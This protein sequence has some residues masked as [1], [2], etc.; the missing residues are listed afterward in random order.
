M[1]NHGELVGQFS[2]GRTAVANNEQIT[3]GIASAVYGAV[4]SA[5][6]ETG[7]NSGDDRPVNI[8]LDGRLIAKSTTRH[9]NQMARVNG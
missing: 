6:S 5:F 1:A 9:Q 8:Y 7:G 2:N 3:E 4:M